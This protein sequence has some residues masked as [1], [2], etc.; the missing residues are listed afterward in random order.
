[1]MKPHAA[2]Y[3]LLKEISLLDSFGQE[4]FTAKHGST[5]CITPSLFSSTPTPC[6]G[7]GP[8]GVTLYHTAEKQ[9]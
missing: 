8:H 7:V 2:E 5:G 9:R 4:V 6:V 1:M 3:W